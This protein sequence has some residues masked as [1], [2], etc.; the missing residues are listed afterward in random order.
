MRL[1]ESEINTIKTWLAQ[2]KSTKDISERFNVS[3]ST[4][5]KIRASSYKG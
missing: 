1:T 3:A 4:I 5:A 2:G